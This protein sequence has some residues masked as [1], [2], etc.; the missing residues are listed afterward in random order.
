MLITPAQ[1]NEGVILVQDGLAE[2]LV[3]GIVVQHLLHLLRELPQLVDE[4][5]TPL[6]GGEPV[7]SQGEGH[8]DQ[9]NEL[10]RVGLGAGHADLRA[11]V[12]VNTTVC[13]P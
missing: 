4:V 11:S 7:M 12:E 6:F 5:L 10:A 13:L 3:V 9:G 1:D 2:F 8:H